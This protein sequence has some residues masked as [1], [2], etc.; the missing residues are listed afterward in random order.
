MATNFVSV[1]ADGLKV[2]L[3]VGCVIS[4]CTFMS[5]CWLDGWSVPWA[6]IISLN[7]GVSHFHAPIG[8]LVDS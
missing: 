1:A 5:V 6:V 8:A 7:G 3:L 2:L 4:L